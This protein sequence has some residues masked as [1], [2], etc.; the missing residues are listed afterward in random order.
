[1]T[2][3]TSTAPE[4]PP[5]LVHPRNRFPPVS[6]SSGYQSTSRTTRSDDIYTISES[7]TKTI[8]II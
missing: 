4:R 2:S 5:P 8:L 3:D 6:G 7:G 1:M